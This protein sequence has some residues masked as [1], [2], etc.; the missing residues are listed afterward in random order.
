MDVTKLR[1][2]VVRRAG[3]A[4]FAGVDL[5]SASGAGGVFALQHGAAV[6]A[7]ALDQ[8]R[9]EGAA[10]LQLLESAAKLTAGQP[11]VGENVDLLA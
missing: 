1:E 4:S 10:V 8:Q 9:A 2:A 7:L 3:S 11:G 6:A 5:L